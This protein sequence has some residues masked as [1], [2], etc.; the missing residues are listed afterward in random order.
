V[1]DAGSH[2][3]HDRFAIA[4][5]IGGGMVPSTIRTCPACGL[6]HADLLAIQRAVRDTWV[7]VL[8]RDL[9]LSVADAIRLRR[10]S[11][12]QR[13]AL[14]GS[15]DDLVTRPLALT[16]ATLG[17]AG[18]LLTSITAGSLFGATGAA[19][20]EV[21]R[22][23][24]GDASGGS[25]AA[26]PTAAASMDTLARPT[27]PLPTGLGVSGGIAPDTRPLERDGS[28]S[29]LSLAMLGFGAVTFLVRRFASWSR[30]VR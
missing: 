21:Y 14:V 28:L 10:R 13:F 5:A 19:P 2:V 9:R 11:W 12:R 1:A 15:P 3:R 29:T 23:A 20:A 25:A 17:L 7:P 6:L 22:A 30:A 27:A 26:A 4:D 16:F 8:P 18:L 24:S